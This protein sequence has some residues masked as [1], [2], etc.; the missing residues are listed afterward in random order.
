VICY[1]A[2]GPG[3]AIRRAHTRLPGGVDSPVA[4]VRVPRE[5]MVGHG[6]ASSLVHE[7][8]HQ[9]AALLSLVE[10]LRPRLQQMRRRAGSEAAMAWGTYE[11]TVSE[12]VADFWSVSTLGISSTLGLLAVVSLPRWV[13]FRPSG[14]DP[15]PMPYLRV[16]I[17]C[18]I[19]QALYPH[20]Q[21]DTLEKVWSSMYPLDGVTDEHRQRIRTMVAIIPDFVAELLDHRPSSLDGRSLRELM[22]VAERQPDRLAELYAQWRRRPTAMAEVSP[23]LAF[24]VLGQARANN[25]LN[26]RSESR[27]VGNLL[28]YWAVRSS[29]DTSAICADA[30]RSR[31]IS[32]AS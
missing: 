4:I 18:A 15:H 6:I 17:S 8:G 9:G 2:R 29:L 30:T 32:Q 11:R 26:P 19:G 10:S 20:R 13:V 16:L 27:V 25:R 28:T 23:A 12:V 3:A 5:R 1:L 7:V 21:W 24:A 14:Q 22:P 31:P